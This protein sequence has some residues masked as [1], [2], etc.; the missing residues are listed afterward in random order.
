M[1]GYVLAIDQGTTSTRAIVFDG[2]MNIVG[3]GQK[4]LTQIYPRSGWVEHEPEDIWDSVL[5]A[6]NMA[7]SKANV[8]TT[9]I[10]ALGITN[11][12][13]TVV[14]WER[15]TGKPI[16]NAIVWQDR[17]TASYCENLKCKDL[18]KIFTKKTG[19]ILD[20]YFS[21]PKLSWIL[22][23][24]KDARARA[25]KCK[26]CF[27]TIDTFL[28]W[29]LTGGK[30]FV[31]D[32]TNASRTLMYNIAENECD[33]DLLN[34]LRVPAVM[35]PEVKDCSEDFGIVEKSI[36]GV[37]IPILGV[38]GDQQAA[39]IGQ[40]CFDPGMLKSTY[41]TGCFAL[42]NTGT[43]MVRSRPCPHKRGSSS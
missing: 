11:Q 12:R 43:D 29:R 34:I 19:L 23:N 41:G 39:M 20:P 28:I 8:Q 1:S 13:E 17:R 38:A 35:L 16:Q 40:A 25:A 9:E 31:T 18:E 4:E 26:L 10:A 36:L 32:A 30:N 22:S 7:L 33:K 27:G 3:V 2:E 15:E 37:E 6:I 5:L 42:L 14:V 24:V 21:C